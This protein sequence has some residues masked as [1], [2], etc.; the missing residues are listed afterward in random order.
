MSRSQESRCEA[1]GA[2]QRLPF[3]P[4]SRY[5]MLSQ[6]RPFG[7]APKLMDDRGTRVSLSETLP[8][9]TAGGTHYPST[10]SW[11]RQERVHPNENNQRN[12]LARFF[13]A[14]RN[15]HSWAFPCQHASW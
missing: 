6:P 15:N 5:L 7:S 9:L 2:L 8:T 11:T 10:W 1:G 14:R 12:I 13:S 3:V 4:A